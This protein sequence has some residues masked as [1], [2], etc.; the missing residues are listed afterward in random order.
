M[1]ILEFPR[2]LVKLLDGESKATVVLLQTMTSQTR[3]TSLSANPQETGWGVLR[4][5]VGK[6]SKL[7]CH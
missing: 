5:H 2:V 4:N 6:N 7:G 3:D 1:C